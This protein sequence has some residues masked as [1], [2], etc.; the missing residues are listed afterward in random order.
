MTYF[1]DHWIESHTIDDVA[2]A[3]KGQIVHSQFNQYMLNYLESRILEDLPVTD[4]SALRREA[5][6]LL[7]EAERIE[8]RPRDEYPEGTVLTFTKPGRYGSGW[9]ANRF[10]T[11][12]GALKY[13][14][15]KA[16]DREACWFLTG[17]A[18]SGKTWDQLLEFIGEENLDTVFY[19]EWDTTH[20]EPDVFKAFGE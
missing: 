17:V 2:R 6:S 15:I 7:A 20:N 8:S 11:F 19:I 12:V 14:A 1:S 4:A 10:D 13:A 16:G 5:A 9:G 3:V 18:T